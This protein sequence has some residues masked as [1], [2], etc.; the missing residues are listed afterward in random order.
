MLY[1]Y[2]KEIKIKQNGKAH[3]NKSFVFIRGAREVNVKNL[4]EYK[5]VD[6]TAVCDGSSS[7]FCHS[8]GS[9]PIRES[10]RPIES[11]NKR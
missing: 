6:K 2:A 9:V 1:R 10:V 11:L 4:R 7:F 5:K 8:G 3:L